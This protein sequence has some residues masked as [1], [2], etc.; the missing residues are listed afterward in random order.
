[1]GRTR[2][3]RRGC[4]RINPGDPPCSVTTTWP[5]RIPSSSVKKKC[6]LG[7]EPVTIGNIVRLS[8]VAGGSTLYDPPADLL[9]P[10]SI[11]TARTNISPRVKAGAIRR[12]SCAV[13]TIVHPPGYYSFVRR[14]FGIALLAQD[15]DV[16]E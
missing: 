3:G 8:W 4:G 12:A 11:W 15:F 2:S 1:M 6:V 10:P 9:W 14:T 16:A 5:E 13:L 7:V